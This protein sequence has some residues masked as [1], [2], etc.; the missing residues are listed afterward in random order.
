MWIKIQRR[1]RR[2]RNNPGNIKRT[3]TQGQKRN[4]NALNLFRGF[5]SSKKSVTLYLTVL[6]ISDGDKVSFKTTWSSG[7]LNVTDLV[8]SPQHNGRNVENELNCTQFTSQISG[9]W[10]LES[11]S[12]D[13]SLG[14][15]SISLRDT[16][17]THEE[18]SQT[19]RPV[20]NLACQITSSRSN[21]GF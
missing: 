3:R 19:F 2:R 6:L 15:P 11:L 12:T 20:Q 8:N 1:G 21:V 13:H 16:C 10:T 17:M 7:I 14:M 5:W 18:S 4:I 9:A